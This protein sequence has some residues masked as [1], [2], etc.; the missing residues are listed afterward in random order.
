M[1]ALQADFREKEGG[2]KKS[3][4]AWLQ[5]DLVKIQLSYLGGLSHMRNVTLLLKQGYCAGHNLTRD[6]H[7]EKKQSLKILSPLH[8]IT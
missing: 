4:T 7:T 5:G 1:L 2:K 6:K 8:L 3:M